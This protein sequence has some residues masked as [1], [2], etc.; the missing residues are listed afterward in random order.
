MTN[1]AISET[2]I[3]KLSCLGGLGHAFTM[4]VY[5][6]VCGVELLDGELNRT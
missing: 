3:Y 1:Y 2:V 5:V 6:V 4:V